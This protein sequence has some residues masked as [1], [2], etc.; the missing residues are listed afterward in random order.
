MAAATSVLVLAAGSLV[1][2]SCCAARSPLASSTRAP[3]LFRETRGDA[4]CRPV[5]LL[6]GIAGSHRYWAEVADELVGDGRL[7]LPDLLGFGASP[8]PRVRYT[9]EEHLRPLR[10]AVVVSVGAEPAILVGHSMGAILAVDYALAYPGSTAGLAL[11]SPPLLA[12][13]S[14]ARQRIEA[15]YGHDGRAWLNCILCRMHQIMGPLARPIA[16]RARPNLPRAVA[17]DATRH[18]WE[19]FRGS[20]DNVLLGPSPLS[21][22]A[23]LRGLPMLIVVGRDDPFVDGDQLRALATSTGAQVEIVDGTH[24]VLIENPEARRLV[25][26]FVRSALGSPAASAADPAS[27]EAGR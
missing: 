13:G 23:G 22:L 18:T 19:S 10:A 15:E 11:V 4:G 27:V 26:A 16:R 17:E 20:L 8:K 24:H 6:H 25:V 9:V 7:V 1:A 12:E 5:V 14:D 21:L 2:T 3:R